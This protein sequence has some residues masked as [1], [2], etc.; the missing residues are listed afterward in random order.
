MISVEGLELRGMETEMG[1]VG[2]DMKTEMDGWMRMMETKGWTKGERGIEDEEGEAEEEE[3]E[4]TPINP[5]DWGRCLRWP[6]LGK[7][8]K[9]DA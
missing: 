7:E 1:D 2:K 5:E 3:G 4:E 8:E 6:M 9:S